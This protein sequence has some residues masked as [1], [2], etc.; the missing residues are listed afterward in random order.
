MSVTVSFI[1]AGPDR[2]G[3]PAINRVRVKEVISIPGTTTATV[4][5]GEMVVVGNGET[6]MVAVAFGTT[7]DAALTAEDGVVSSAGYPVG[8]GQVSDPLAPAAGAKVN[9]KAA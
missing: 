1:L 2:S 9:I 4:A 5:A 3:L 6:S 8:A 7:P